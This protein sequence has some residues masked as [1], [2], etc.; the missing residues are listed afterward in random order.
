MMNKHVFE[1]SNSAVN[2]ATTIVTILSIGA[3]D[4]SLKNRLRTKVSL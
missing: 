2:T 4:V 1:V 3:V